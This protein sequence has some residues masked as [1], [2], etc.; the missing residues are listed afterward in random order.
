[1]HAFRAAVEQGDIEAAL[2]CLSPVVRFRSPVVYRPYEGKD[3][4]SVLL[5]NV[6]EV[7]EDF[8]YEDELTTGPRTVLF[9]RARV[10]DKTL[11]GLDDLTVGGDGL[12]VD[13][14]VMV[15]PLSGAIALAEA[16]GARL[17]KAP[18]E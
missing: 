5:R 3:A 15:R 9:F 18:A 4:V 10:G 11:E 8:A 2:A 17:Q 1:M 6:F 7:F 14:R 12:I 13:F 16:M